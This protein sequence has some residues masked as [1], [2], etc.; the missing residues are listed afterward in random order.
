MPL[1]KGRNKGDACIYWVVLA[2]HAVLVGECEVPDEFIHMP[3]GMTES[4]MAAAGCVVGK[5]YP[6]PLVHGS[7][8]TN[9]GDL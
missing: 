4:Q 8:L 9:W 3:W 5:D 7:F 6:A 1:S 2:F